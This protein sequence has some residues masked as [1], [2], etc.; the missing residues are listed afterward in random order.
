MRKMYFMLA[1][2]M[3][4][5]A[6]M[7]QWTKPA[8][9]AQPMEVGQ[10]CYLYNVK[11]EGF[12]VGANDYGTRASVGTTLGHKVKIEQ[13]TSES[14]YYL[15]NYVLA[16]GMANQWGYMFIEPFGLDNVYVDNTKDGKKDNQFTFTDKGDHVYQIGLSPQNE[17][18]KDELEVWTMSSRTA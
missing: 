10:E 5:L 11:A 6:S 17:N 3:V 9:Q 7:A 2:L 12:L 8:L 4:S 1:S 15:T 13:G 14:S 18:W 16:G